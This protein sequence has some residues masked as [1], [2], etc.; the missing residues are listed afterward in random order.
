MKV[1]RLQRE[2]QKKSQKRL[3]IMLEKEAD[4]NLP[5][6]A[7]VVPETKSLS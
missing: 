6:V 1:I 5:R 7:L 2:G 4:K 3:W